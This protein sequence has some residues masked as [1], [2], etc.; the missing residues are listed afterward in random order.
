MTVRA[1]RAPVDVSVARVDVPFDIYHR[2]VPRLFTID[3]DPLQNDDQNNHMSL[4]DAPHAPVVCHI[5]NSVFNRASL[6]HALYGF[7]FQTAAHVR[8]ELTRP[9]DAPAD[10]A[11]AA[12]GPRRFAE[13]SMEA[14]QLQ[15]NLISCN[16][17]AIAN[18]LNMPS[19]WTFTLHLH[20]SPYFGFAGLEARVVLFSPEFNFLSF[21]LLGISD[22]HTDVPNLLL[23][24]RTLCPDVHRKLMGVQIHL[25]HEQHQTMIA[26]SASRVLAAFYR[27]APAKPLFFTPDVQ[28]A[29]P[30]P[31][32]LPHHLAALSAHQINQLVHQYQPRLQLSWTQSQ[33]NQVVRD[34][35]ALS[36]STH[37]PPVPQHGTHLS[38]ERSWAFAQRDYR[39]LRLFVGGLA[40]AFLYKTPQPDRVSITA[41][42]LT[43]KNA[44]QVSVVADVILQARQFMQLR[45]FVSPH[46]FHQMS[47]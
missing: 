29:V 22:P 47:H 45:R 42:E 11:E 14:A 10:A 19:T 37:L 20:S 43:S 12:G 44:A 30:E 35:S 41:L 15:R 16:L 2:L 36:R 21:H 26:A 46:S 18:L 32:L 27:L 28:Q 4:C 39:Q 25:T 13:W 31:P 34:L 33:I 24:L 6:A 38:F 17:V 7:S 23:L 1:Q 40:T 9:A 5:Q 3:G 8:C